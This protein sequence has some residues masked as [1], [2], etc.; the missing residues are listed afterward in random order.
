M[1]D[2]WSDIQNAK[3]NNEASVETRLIIPLLHTLGYTDDDICSKYPVVFHEGRRGRKPEA[4]FV[5]FYGPIQ[6][7]NTSLITIEAKTPG[8]PFEDAKK[9]GESYAANIRTPFLLLTDGII[10]EVWQ[11]QPTQESECILKTLVKSL[12]SARGKIELYLNKESVRTYCHSLLHK[13]IT[14]ATEDFGNYEIAELKRTNFYQPF[15]KRTLV[16]QKEKSISSKELLSLYPSGAIILAPSGFGKT[17]LSYKLLQQ[18]IEMRQSLEATKLPFDLPLPDWAESE[19]SV[20][21]FMKHRITAYYPGIT[22]SS[23]KDLLRDKGA[24][25]IC[26]DFDRL[27]ATK[28]RKIET[29]IKNLRRDFTTLQFFIFSRGSKRPISSLPTLELSEFSTEQQRELCDQFNLP[30]HLIPDNLYKLCTHPLLLKR[31]LDYWQRETKLPS[32]IEELFRFWV[33]SLLLTESG[34]NVSSI[35]CEAALTLLAKETIDTPVNKVK[36]LRLLKDN[37]FSEMVLDQLLGYDAIRIDG[38]TLALQ[39]EALADYLRA[40][41]IVTNEEDI[42]HQIIS[43]L[44]LEGD[45]F[46]P[47]LLMAL[48]PSRHLQKILWE[49][50]S[51]VNLNIYFDSLRYR[52]D[53][54]GK[55][56]KATSDDFSFQYLEDLIEGI[57]FPL[58]GFFPQLQDIVIKQLANNGDHEMAITGWEN[59]NP[60]QVDFA[61]HSLENGDKITVGIP[62]DQY[63]HHWA[64][65]KLSG[66]RL[67]SGR[68]LG[69]KHLKENLFKIIANRRLKGDKTWASERLIGRLRYMEKEYRIPLDELETL[70]SLKN[71]LKPD[72]DKFV[73]SDSFSKLP[74]F[75]IK[76]LLDDISILQGYGQ[77]TLDFWWIRLGWKSAIDISDNV[78]K[79]LLD[80]HFRRLQ[81]VYK[82][83]IENSFKTVSDQFGFYWALPV[84]WDCAVVKSYPSPWLNEKWFPVSSWNEIGAD[85]EFSESKPER[86]NW[87][88]FSEI[89]NALLSLSRTKCNS[90]YWG[91]AG[92]MPRFDGYNLLGRY[93]GETTVVRSVCKLIERDIKRL[94]DNLPSS[95]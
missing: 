46:F 83:I 86:F 87:N 59:P 4:D 5:V 26:D 63:N 81:L 61:F 42:I 11:L 15:I 89:Q 51:H 60:A 1:F 41:D 17:T 65:L 70:E 19:V 80:E 56:I 95:D 82:E 23:L 29:E 85:T 28:Q 30:T 74:N 48:L 54:S 16:E 34:Q 91:C 25:L 66:Y 88:G 40:L 21:E 31:T 53:I 84:R 79:K 92:L 90:F 8:E 12:C 35:N 9:Q 22:D 43:S 55:M 20:L 39:H 93:D 75:P 45:S 68:L 76:E 72:A 32:K 27:S 10:L 44:S 13:N 69:A 71:F 38:S 67:D 14:I 58:N 77:N 57:E 78:M 36:A 62:H 18:A 7:K 73:S 24:I 3:F 33:D 52:S 2:F 64:N 47:I 50:L 49:K 6:D 94:F 37:D